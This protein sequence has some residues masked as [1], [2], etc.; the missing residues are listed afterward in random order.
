M[1]GGSATNEQTWEKSQNFAKQQDPVK[2]LPIKQSPTK[3]IFKEFKIILTE[4][5]GKI[6]QIT[7]S[8]STN[9]N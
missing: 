3:A 8:L 9:H 7:V 1:W 5:R 6:K 2:K 4:E